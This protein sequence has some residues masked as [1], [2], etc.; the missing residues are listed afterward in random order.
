MKIAIVSPSHVPYVY[1]GLEGL[2]WKLTEAINRLTSHQAELIK[3]PSPESSFWDHVDS[4]HQFYKLDLSHFDL[5]ISTKYP[6]WMVRHQNHV[7]Y[8]AHHLRALFDTYNFTNQPEMVPPHMSSG[9]V[10]EILDLIRAGDHSEQR[11]EEVFEKLDCLRKEASDYN[12]EIFDFPGPFIREIIHFFD[13]YALSPQ[14]ISRYTSISDNVARRNDYF[15]IGVQV[16]TVYPPSNID[17]FRWNGYDY[18]FTASRLDGLKRINLLVEAMKYVPH[19]IKLKIAGTGLEEER[20]KS[21]ASL[22]SRVE[23]LSFVNEETLVD[24]YSKALAVLYVP[25]DEDYGLITIEAMMSGKP[26]ITASDSGGPLEFVKDDQTGYVVEPDPQKIAEK[27]N[28]LIGNPQEARRMGVRARRRVENITWEGVMARLF[29]QDSIIIKQTQNAVSDRDSQIIALNDQL[30]E[31]SNRTKTLALAI[32]DRDSQITTLSKQ[33]QESNELTTSLYEEI[34]EMKR[35]VV[36]QMTMRF[37]E[38]FVEKALPVDS[39]QRRWY[40]LGLKSGRILLNEG[41]GTFSLRFKQY[42]NIST[43]KDLIKNN[44][45]LQ[46]TEYRGGNGNKSSLLKNVLVMDYQIPKYDRDAGSLRL[47]KILKI[48]SE[49]SKVT[50]IGTDLIKSE[51]YSSDLEALGIQTLYYPKINSVESYLEK[52]GN[53]FDVIIISRYD[54]AIIY[55]RIAKKFCANAKIIFDTVDLNFLRESRRAKIEN[56]KQLL[57]KV[58]YMKSQE[59]LLAEISDATIVVSPFE[60][61]LLL[62]ENSKLN[63]YIVST[64]YDTVNEVKPF[65]KRKD[66]LFIGGFHH[67]P[68]IDAVLFFANEIF[69]IIKKNLI[70]VKFYIIGSDPTPEIRS[71]G[72]QDIIVTGYVKDVRP[73]FENSRVFVA[74]LR[75]GAGIKG[76]INQSSSYGLPVVTTS[77]GAEG[78]DLIDEEDALI[79]DTPEMFANKVIEL[80]NN[81]DLWCKLSKSSIETTKRKYSYEV[82]KSELSKIIY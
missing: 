75:Y 21:L 51:S 62:R 39:R 20:L 55:L 61:E 38:G 13:S 27:I 31:E 47:F 45:N 11:V 5:I 14:R 1:G 77:I 15:P 71:L 49:I 46:L 80:Y 59:L 54:L 16:E 36:W 28:Y 26:V 8:M 6:T 57:A 30:Q 50:F 42:M 40:E 12:K 60:K 63:I 19:D 70:D 41:W 22:D 48:L 17:T 10:G 56:D 35:S 81:G 52:C 78:M 44:N 64:I 72:S 76:K 32:A 37:H 43:N 34:V 67:P 53:N 24:L 4:Y 18:L 25:Y 74:P 23:F 7:V 66:I 82:A 58:V 3:L 65:Q 2:T 69:P 9:L 68:N 29:G 73:Y 33:L 79:A